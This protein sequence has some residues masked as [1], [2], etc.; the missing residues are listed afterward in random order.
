MTPRP[1]QPL[2]FRQTVLLALVIGIA[3]QT[4]VEA[5]ILLPLLIWME[6]RAR[7]TFRLIFIV[8]VAL[9][10]FLYASWRLAPSPVWD[11]D[12]TKYE[13]RGRVVEVNGM[14]GNRLR[15]ILDDVI[16][17]KTPLQGKLVLTWDNPPYRPISG[18]NLSVKMRVRPSDGFR[19]SNAGDSAYWARKGVYWRGYTSGSVKNPV[20]DG[21]GSPLAVLR[22]TLRLR[23][24]DK[25][26]SLYPEKPSVDEK[27]RPYGVSAPPPS[28]GWGMLPAFLF[29][30][31]FYIGVEQMKQLS[32]AGLAHS[33]ALS[34]Q[35]LTVAGLFAFLFVYSV[36]YIRPNMWLCVSRVTL[37]L[38]CSILLAA[39]YLWLGNAPF[40]LWRSFLMMSF[41]ALFI[42]LRRPS[43]FPDAMLFAFV[44]MVLF[45]PNCLTDIGVQLSFASVAGIALFA[46]SLNELFFGLHSSRK[47]S[48]IKLFFM[49]L[50][51]FFLALTA[52]SIAVQIST[53]PLVVHIFGR[54]SPYFLLNLVWL[55]ILGFYILPLAFVAFISMLL[56]LD[57]ISSWAFC[58]AVAPCRWLFDVLEA[59]QK[60]GFLQSLWLPR[61]SWL[62]IL[63]WGVLIVSTALM[64]HRQR[65]PRKIILLACFGIALI[66]TE[67][68]TWYICGYSDSVSLRVLDVGQGQSVLIELP[69]HKRM[70][71]DGGGVRSDRFDTGRDIVSPV[72][73]HRAPLRLEW[74]ALTHADTDHIRGLFFIARHYE[75]GCVLVPQDIG[76]KKLWEQFTAIL[77]KRNIPIKKL[78]C[79]DTIQLDD[80]IIA[81][82]LAP[83]KNTDESDGSSGKAKTN[84]DGLILRFVKNGHGLAVLVGDA[85]ISQQKKIVRSLCDCSADILIAPHHGSAKNICIDFIE[86]VAPREVLVSA[87]V[88]NRYGFPSQELKNVLK[89]RG[90]GLRSTS[91]EGELKVSW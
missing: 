16:R 79:G 74:L 38:P 71:V 82:V 76:D 60:S 77:K 36:G 53:F 62:G 4:W 84:N 56:G 44:C 65:I 54:I 45:E 86:S 57:C 2:L 58:G 61:F 51:W 29:G 17:S 59:M 22:E 88:G 85:S 28:G 68:L 35:H 5:W 11:G 48:G 1:L 83:F 87:G 25:L 19:N 30:D 32:D 37:L 39:G 3:L 80:G 72:L 41:W 43:A 49:K 14:V 73:S 89:E 6:G 90:I 46:S 33:I 69:H 34:G 8:G 12:T 23:L 91:D 50:L 26:K 21:V 10:G 81:E 18:E 66:C 75:I 7:T 70:L 52:T 13:V 24:I 31:R 9:I 64:L 42:T 27:P 67:P 47:L 15:I 78:A 55:P 20:R 40:S 63:G